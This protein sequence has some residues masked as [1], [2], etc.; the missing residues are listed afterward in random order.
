MFHFIYKGKFDC[1][2]SKDTFEMYIQSLYYNIK[3]KFG[4][5][6]N[7]KKFT[8]TMEM[9]GKDKRKGYGG[10]TNENYP[11]YELRLQMFGFPKKEQT[12]DL[13]NSFFGNT[14]THELFHL[15]I[16]SVQDNSC[17]S[18]G[19]TDFMTFWY[20]NTIFENLSRLQHD[21]NEITDEKYKAH[22]YGYITGLK[23]MVTLYNK[24]PSIMDDMKKIIKEYDRTKEYTA[25]H[26]IAYN[27]KFKTF[28]TGRCNKH[29]PHDLT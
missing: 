6:Y 25:A 16:P 28:F 18:E 22:K 11:N 10:N 14:V 23:K 15:F 27:P 5:T 2:I 29:I 1:L 26:I 12:F 13:L 20:H 4:V 24:D 7:P 19:V 3:R 9:D 21:Y 8:I 17:W